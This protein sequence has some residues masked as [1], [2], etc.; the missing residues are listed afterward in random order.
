MDIQVKAGRDVMNQWV[1]VTVKG[2]SGQ[3][4]SYVTTML[5]GFPIGDDG[6]NPPEGSYERAW[7]Q[8]GTGAPNQTHN[9]LV[10]ATDQKGN[11]ES[12]SKTWQD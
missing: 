5:D 8:V 2:G 12:A 9:V 3:L 11:Q 10:T 1:E 6:L 4:I 7:H